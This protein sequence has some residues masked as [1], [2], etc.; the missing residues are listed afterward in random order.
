MGKIIK[1]IP[2]DV[3]GRLTVVARNGVLPDGTIKYRCQCACGNEHTVAGTVLRQGLSRSCGCLVRENK[4]S[5]PMAD[6]TVPAFNQVIVAYKRGARTRGLVWQLTD[7]D[8]RKL[9]AAPC[10]YCG[11][12]ETN[13]AVKTR[14]T[15]EPSVFKYNGIDRCDP[16]EGYV[17]S[18]VVACCYVDNRAKNAMSMA[19]Y[20][21]WL[22]R[23]VAHR[24]RIS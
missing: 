7:D 14:K 17:A 8:C 12:A 15:A 23:L 4:G 16:S 21:A 19:E 20:L 13:T 11:D 3:F 18:N 5:T 6:R 1:T 2:G 24:S 9:F 22:D 10:Y